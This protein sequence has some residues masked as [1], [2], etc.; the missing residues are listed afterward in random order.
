MSHIMGHKENVGMIGDNLAW[1]DISW[2][3][4]NRI[5][6]NL[7]K[8]IFSARQKGDLK[9]V[10]N[11]QKLMLRSQS[12][13]L[14][15]VRR[16]TQIN[17]GK[18]TAGV[19]RQLALSKEDRTILATAISKH[20]DLWKPLPTKRVEIPKSNGKKRPL[21]IP[22]IIDRTLQNVHKNA[23]EPE[24][25]AMFE[26][27]SYGFRPGR[28]TH[29][30]MSKI[31]SNIKGKN[32][33]KLWVVEG[34]IKGCFDN[35]NHE[36]LLEKIGSYP[37]IDLISKWLKAGFIHDG[38]YYDTKTGT[39]QG[40]IISPLLSNIA[41]DGL[42]EK[43]DIKYSWQKDK[44]SP[45]G[46]WW[47]NKTSRTY[48]KYADDFIVLC[49][50]HEDACTVKELLIKELKNQGL[51]LSKEKTR[52]THLDKGFDF[53]G[54]NFRR[55]N[56]TCRNEG[57]I[58]YIKPSKKN[59]QDFK[60]RLKEV[61]KELNGHNQAAVISKLNPIIRGWANYHKNVV[62]KKTFINLDHYIFLKL[63][64]WGK[65]LHHRKSWGQIRYHYWGK[66]CPG[67]N[68]TWVFGYKVKNSKEYFSYYLEKL[69][70]TSITRH[71]TVLFKNS[72][73]DPNKND[74]WDKRN[75]QNELKRLSQ[76]VSKGKCDIAKS[77]DYLCRWCNQGITSE[78]LLNTQ[79]HHIVPRRLKGE[80]TLKN[81]IYL[82]SECHRQVTR[83]G[84]IKPST[85]SRLGVKVTFFKGKQRWKVKKK[86]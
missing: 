32:P 13:I 33:H 77:T 38:T 78:G 43:L 52:I 69:A 24:W 71:S 1:D 61:F 86:P 80:D 31:F 29:D 62:S 35:I 30:A 49:E 64:K 6:R 37:G 72:P 51:E 74:Y 57:K 54:W 4:V 19:D 18:N 8:R 68:D 23:L 26:P 25:E 7:R 15:S 46:G 58:V 11:L 63:K 39:P 45:L 76:K 28:S 85:L 47:L 14:S 36:R 42:E 83:E 50:S 12:N 2:K 44:R 60:D 65:R 53:L 16:V 67:R 41:L 55:Y 81:K 20:R 84:E 73:D 3:K 59:T 40:G 66:F 75:K 9:R 79:I 17:K 82:H 21:G 70:W 56:S 27:V 22:T 5:I 48:V 34:D 10:R